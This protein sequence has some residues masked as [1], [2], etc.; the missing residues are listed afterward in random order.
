MQ[1]GG[2][3]WGQHV[4]IRRKC[5]G[6]GVFGDQCGDDRGAGRAGIGAVRDADGGVETPLGEGDAGDTVRVGGAWDGGDGV[7]TIKEPAVTAA[8]LESQSRTAHRL[9]G[10]GIPKLG[11]HRGGGIGRE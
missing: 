10:G 5:Q 4:D 9:A 8:D 1:R 6:A 7:C 11:T 2:H 3:A